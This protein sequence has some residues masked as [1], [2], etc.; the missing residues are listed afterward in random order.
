M[1]IRQAET[2]IAQYEYELQVA[3]ESYEEG[4][5]LYATYANVLQEKEEAIRKVKSMISKLKDGGV[6]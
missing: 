3:K 1:T 6:G 5:L 4:Y 2:L